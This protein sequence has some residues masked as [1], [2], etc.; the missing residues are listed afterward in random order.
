MKK[1]KGIAQGELVEVAFTVQ[2]RALILDHTFAGP[3]LMDRLTMAQI[4]RNK[5]VTKFS[6]DDLDEL[7]G[8][9]AAEANHTSDRKLER[10][11]DKLYGR[12]KA[13]MEAF[14]DGQW[15]QAF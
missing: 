4:Q 15:Q 2:E 11:L 3:D 13:T 10:S 8:Y 1:R 14:D 6:L 5:L 9:I 12:L 7:L